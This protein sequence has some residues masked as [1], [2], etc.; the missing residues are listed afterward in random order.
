MKRY[1]YMYLSPEKLLPDEASTVRGCVD[2]KRYTRFCDFTKCYVFQRDENWQTSF[3]CPS[4]ECAKK[5]KTNP[6]FR[7]RLVPLWRPISSGGE[8]L[9]AVMCQNCGMVVERKPST[10]IETVKTFIPKGKKMFRLPPL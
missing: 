9:I 10:V 8:G 2:M 6:Y 3:V 4:S 7:D 5:R 1:A